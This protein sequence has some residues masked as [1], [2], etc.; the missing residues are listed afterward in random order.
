[1]SEESKKRL[2]IP[3][4]LIESPVGAFFKSIGLELE[5][6]YNGQSHDDYC[7]ILNDYLPEVLTL[8]RLKLNS[9][10]IYDDKIESRVRAL[11]TEENITDPNVQSL[12]KSFMTQNDF[13]LIE[14]YSNEFKTMTSIKIDDYLNVGYFIDTIVVEA[15]KNGSDYDCI[16]S[17]LN[18]VFEFAFKNIEGKNLSP[19]LDVLYS[20]SDNVFAVEVKFEN[21]TFKLEETFGS[22][23]QLLNNFVMQT[24]YFHINYFTKRNRLTLSSAWFK[25][26]ALKNFKSYFLSETSKRMSSGVSEAQVTL[27]IEEKENISYVPRQFEEEDLQAKKLALSRKFALF[28][29]KHHKNNDHSKNIMSLTIN[30]IRE[31]LSHYPF[32]EALDGVDEEV[33]NFILKLVQDEKLFEGIDNY[34]QSIASSN[35]DPHMD[36]IKRLISGKSLS[37]IDEIIRINGVTENK[38]DEITIVKGWAEDQNDEK[39]EVKKGQLIEKLEEESIRIKSNGDNII[40]DDIIRVVS[41]ELNLPSENAAIVVKE[42]THEAVGGELAQKSKLEDSF[43]L[44]LLS[45]SS[46]NSREEK[47]EK[48]IHRMKKIMMEMKTEMLKITA[49]SEENKKLV[50]LSANSI[51]SAE[52]NETKLALEQT[53]ELLKNS[54]KKSAKQ[55][56]DLEQML[57]VKQHTIENL[58]TKIEEMKAEYSQ[59]QEFANREKLEALQVE[60]KSLNQRLDFAMKK[61]NVINENM[62][63]QS[64][65]TTLKKDKEIATLKAS[66]QMAQA[67]IEKVKLERNDFETKFLEEKEKLSKLR[68]DTGAANLSTSE[69]NEREKML[70]AEKKVLEEK[71]RAQT[72]ELKK[73]EQKLRF[74]IAQ[75]EDFQKRRPTQTGQSPSKS[76]DVHLKQLES[77][78]SRLAEANSDLVDKKKELIKIKQ[79]NNTLVLKI[80]ELEK[81]VANVSKKAA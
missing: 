7:F 31:Y 35:L 21:N 26:K 67:I 36:K 62:E 72:I 1:M 79:E 12:I 71:F 34:V 70:L 28:C 53:K 54:E 4:A 66:I 81:K 13:E 20:F 37:D 46:N 57:E 51:S 40:Q 27:G 76:S 3:K 15:Y 23:S 48:H 16:R 59:S 43:A 5:T 9:Q 10:K 64:S 61:V 50:K 77:A 58:E 30:D 6:T 17:Y 25:D 60:N 19:V 38:K 75:L 29:K 2:L 73:Q 44:K 47:L 14:S 32:Q 24:N 49:E 22:K 78:N 55:K 65:E 39:W 33:E 69:H 42:I 56:M 11:I 41:S 80:A 45:Q 18:Q 52:F 8:P 63:I 74:T 68:D